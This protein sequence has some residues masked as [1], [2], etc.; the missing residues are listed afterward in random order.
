MYACKENFLIFIQPTPH[1]QDVTQ[2][3]FLSRL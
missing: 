3:N 2:C 1:E